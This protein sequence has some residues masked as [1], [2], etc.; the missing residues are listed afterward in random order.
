MKN[1]K[2][3]PFAFSAMVMALS[4]CGGESANIIP[5]KY[6]TSTANGACQS[7]TEGCVE[8]VLDYPLDGLNFTCSSDSANT[9]VTKFDMNESIAS[10][11]C[12]I[13]DTVTF[14]LMGSKEKK[15]DLGS[16]KLSTIS[17]V[18]SS[19]TPPRLTLLDIARG[20]NGTA[21]QSLT[22]TDKTVN[23]A[24]RLAKIIQAI[25]LKDSK[26]PS[27]TEIQPVYM[28]DINREG[29]ESI[30]RSITPADFKNLSD[31][32]FNKLLTPWLDLN[33]VSNADAFEVVNKLANISVAAVFQP[34]F[35]LY[36]TQQSIIA[37]ISG[38]DGMVGCDKDECSPLDAAKTN[39][40]GHFMLLTDRQRATFGSGV[41]WRGKIDTSF[42]TIGGVNLQLMLKVKPKQITATQQ[43]NWIDP[44]TKEI[45]TKRSL[46][47]KFD[48]DETGAQPLTITQGTL[49]ADK[50]VVGTAGSLYRALMGLS[51]TASVD[52]AK[53]KLGLWYEWVNGT[54]YQG[55]LDL[56]KQFPVSYLDRSVFRTASN[57]AKLPNTSLTTEEA[58]RF[59]YYFPM[60][61]DLTFTFT[62]KDIKPVVLGIV[63]DRNG[64]IR[65]NIKPGFDVND[66]NNK[67]L[68]KV[69]MSTGANGCAGADVLE[70]LLMKDVQGVTQ[71]RIGTVSRAFTS[72]YTSNPNSL[73]LR[74]I[75]ADQVFG[76]LNGALVG[77]NTTIKT[78]ND[79]AESVV[80]GGALLRLSSLMNESAGVPSNNAVLFKDSAGNVVKWANTY[81]SFNLTY[82]NKNKDDT[83][84]K[85]LAKLAGGEIGFKLAPCYQVKANQ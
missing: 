65:T 7:S 41:Q 27:A 10:G 28:N 52:G 19:T 58:K 37:G 45:D 78:S 38:S 42:N 39:L 76:T 81:A 51:S 22:D 46:G 67:T 84:S 82:S 12:K 74:M 49:L 59:N 1:K 60:Y 14:Y 8:F 79:S 44:L 24:M 54:K 5:E 77:M 80:I 31:A 36:S 47:F 50:M 25:W 34:E 35:A 26:I 20:I 33:A 69:D 61:A 11:A 17:N 6:D 57:T 83:E 40:F 43:D 66:F 29:L 68:D 72:S 62:D 4:G 18:A 71:Y 21:A 48:V 75:L 85:A 9:F 2:I 13:G 64:D 70:P 55:T 63:I 53:S 23:V 30:G 32:D 73:S 56:Y 16:M 15:I 3:L